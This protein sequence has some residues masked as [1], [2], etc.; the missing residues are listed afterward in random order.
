MP[1]RLIDVDAFREDVKLVDS[2]SFGGRGK[3]IALSHVWGK[4]KHFKTETINLD[5]HRIRIPFGDLPKTFRDAVLA[6]RAL[7]LRYLWIDS[8]CIIQDSP[9]DWKQEASLMASVYFNA[10]ATISAA[11]SKDSDSGLFFDRD[12][13]ACSVQLSYTTS[14]S[15]VGLWTVHNQTPSFDQQI[16]HTTLAS[17]A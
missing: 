14:S 5:N 9:A 17:R 2:A 6:T 8:I 7:G 3:Y 12:P 10:Y 16:R 13:P 4:G 1:T 11:A 15:A